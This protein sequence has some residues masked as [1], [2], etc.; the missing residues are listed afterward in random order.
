MWV[1][2]KE[3]LGFGHTPASWKLWSF[4]IVCVVFAVTIFFVSYSLA[5]HKRMVYRLRV[6]LIA[7]EAILKDKVAQAEALQLQLQLHTLAKKTGEQAVKRKEIKKQI[8]Q[9]YKDLDA[10]KQKLDKDVKALNQKRMEELLEQAR[11]LERDTL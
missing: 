3:N 10:S 11:Q 5:R 2:V 6:Q 4:I 8:K 9:V 7:Q 1:N